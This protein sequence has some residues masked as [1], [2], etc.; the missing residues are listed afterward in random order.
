MKKIFSVVL[1]LASAGLVVFLVADRLTMKKRMEKIEVETA[2]TANLAASAEKNASMLRVLQAVASSPAPTNQGS[3]T[4]TLRADTLPKAGN[5]AANSATG[6]SVPPRAPPSHD[7]QILNLQT[8]FD[9]ESIDRSWAK[10]TE[11]EIV[12]SIRPK[13]PASSSIRSAECKNTLCR[14]EI[15][16]ASN[17]E[18][19]KFITESALLWTGI[20]LISRKMATDRDEFTTTFFS[21][22]AGEQFPTFE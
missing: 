20:T 22:K 2:T 3:S 17:E 16:H 9:E 5:A 15:A 19:E 13:L 10:T 21:L 8:K 7:E 6:S 11:S 18:G 14:I 1:V 12:G 4:E